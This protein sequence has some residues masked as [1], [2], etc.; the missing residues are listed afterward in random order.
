VEIPRPSCSVSRPGRV[1]LQQGRLQ[2]SAREGASGLNASVVSR[3]LPR[4]ANPL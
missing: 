2:A 1:R 3:P 4:A